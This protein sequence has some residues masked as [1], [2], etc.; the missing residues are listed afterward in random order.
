MYGIPAHIVAVIKHFYTDFSCSVG[1][2]D[3]SFLVKL[4]V[5]QGCVMAAGLCLALSSTGFHAE[6]Q[7]KEKGNTLDTDICFRRPRLCR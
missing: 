5:R 6:Q 2:S 3:L 7:R 1:S 4:G